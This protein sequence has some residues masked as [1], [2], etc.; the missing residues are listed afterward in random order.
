MSTPTVAGSS[1]ETNPSRRCSTVRKRASAAT[2]ESTARNTVGWKPSASTIR[3]GMRPPAFRPVKPTARPVAAKATDS[4]PRDYPDDGMT[5]QRLTAVRRQQGLASLPT[6]ID[7]RSPLKIRPAR[8]APCCSTRIPDYRLPE[9]KVSGGKGSKIKLTYSEALFDERAKETA[10]KSTAA[11]AADSRTSSCPT[12]P[13]TV[14]PPAVV[15]NLSLYPTDIETGAAPLVVE[16]RTASARAIR[17]SARLS[18]RTTLHWRKFGNGWRTARLCA[19]ETYFDC[20]Y[21]EQLQYAGDTRIQALI[22]LYVSGDDRLVRK[23]IRMY[24]LRARTRNHLQPLPEPFQYSA[25]FALL[26]RHDPR[27]LDAP[28]RRRFRA[29]ASYPAS[30][31]CCR[32]SPKRSIRTR[33]C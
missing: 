27:L 16:D 10:T 23:A 28:Q 15:Q 30:A 14:V 8:N 24:D 31:P 17:S 9:P 18:N 19:H 12:E 7:G 33:A 32:G 1:C 20:P 25:F 21:Y 2:T 11:S 22:S 6:F 13:T 5:E 4:D 29:Q 3:N 26:D